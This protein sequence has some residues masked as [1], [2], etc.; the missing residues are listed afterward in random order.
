[1]SARSDNPMDT[2]AQAVTDLVPE[3][4]PRL[5]DPS[6]E[7]H[8]QLGVVGEMLLARVGATRVISVASSKTGSWIVSEFD[9]A[10]GS[11]NVM[12][13][14]DGDV[15]DEQ[16]PSLVLAA[17]VGS[18]EEQLAVS[19]EGAINADIRPAVTGLMESLRDRQQQ[20]AESVA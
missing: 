2:V 19:G 1:M 10:G 9:T 12:W 16:I 7:M 6:P 14:E 11:L 4:E 20:L 8:S 15:S 13:T 17:A 5:I 18:L 3:L